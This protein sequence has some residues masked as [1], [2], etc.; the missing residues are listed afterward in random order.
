[1]IAEIEADKGN[2]DIEAVAGGVLLEVVVPVGT[3]VTPGTIIGYIGTPGQ[4]RYQRVHQ[5]RRFRLQ[6]GRP[7]ASASTC[8][9]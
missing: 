5:Q 8:R 4:K 6:D 3:K 1:M 9:R 7:L 2:L